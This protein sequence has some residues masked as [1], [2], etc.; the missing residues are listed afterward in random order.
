MSARILRIIIEQVFDIG[1]IREKI[2]GFDM[3]ACEADSQYI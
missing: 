2:V 1:H 3:S